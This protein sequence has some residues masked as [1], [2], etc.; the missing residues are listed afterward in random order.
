MPDQVP[1]PVK[2]RR[3]DLL[4]AMT[5]AQAAAFR[6][7][8]RGERETLLLEEICLHEGR[9]YWTGS[10]AR[11]V[12]GAVPAEAFQ[13]LDSE[14]SPAAASQEMAGTLVEGTFRG[15]IIAFS[16]GDAMLFSPL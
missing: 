14:E 9:N 15:D 10:T 12:T 7:Q 6:A 5:A 1:E 4:L 13:P 2:A 11:Y 8:F 3:S 16:R